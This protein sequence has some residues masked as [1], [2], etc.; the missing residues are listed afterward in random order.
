M[1]L[2]DIYL[3]TFLALTAGSL[4][5]SCLLV[6]LLRFWRRVP[7]VDILWIGCLLGCFAAIVANTSLH[8]RLFVSW[9]RAQN[10]AVPA[11]GCVTYEPDFTRLYATYRMTRP[12]FDAWIANHPWKLKPG[13]NGLLHHDGPRFGLDEP[14]AG[15]ETE[16]APNG[17]QLRVYFKSGIMYVSYNSM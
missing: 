14:D 4:V 9:H 16:M 3:K 13:D 12:E 6:S 15:F 5:L 11:T 7:W 10:D 2:G 1:N 17:R 8:R